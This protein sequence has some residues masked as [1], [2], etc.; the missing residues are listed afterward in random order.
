[1]LPAARCGHGQVRA[2]LL[3]HCHELRH[4]VARKEWRIRRRADDMGETVLCRPVEPGKHSGERPCRPFDAVLD[5]RQ[6]I[7]A[8]TRRFAVG[9]DDQCLRLRFESFYHVI[10][11]WLSRQADHSFVAPA[12]SPG[13]S[14]CKD[15]P[16]NRLIHFVRRPCADVCGPP[17]PRRGGRHRTRCALGLR[18]R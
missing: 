13:E 17:L 2:L 10:E 11:Q 8:K 1:M 7:L 18:V 9:V 16:R 14:P 4:Q 12:H 3:L 6:P 5:H 15:N